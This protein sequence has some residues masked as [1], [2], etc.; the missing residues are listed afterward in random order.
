MSLYKRNNSPNWYYR[1]T[2]PGGG[3]VVQGSTGTSNKAHA[4]ELYDRL[5]V[6]LWNQAKLGHKPR[7]LW[8]D[9][10]VRYVGDRE[11]LSSLET[12]KTHLRWLDPH[13][14]GVALADIDRDRVDAI[15][16]AKRCEPRVVRTRNGPKP[17][18]ETIGEGT[19]RR[20][21]GVLMAVLHA[22][23]EWEWLDRA[24]V[25]KR[26][27]TTPKRV[28]WITPAQAERL[29]AELPAHLSDMARFSL[30]TG[31]RRSNVTGL[32]WSQVDLARRVAWIHPDQAK[33]RKAITVPLSDTAV[34][35]LRRQLSK[36]RAAEHIER[37]FVYRGSAI[38][39]P[40]TAAW[41][42]ALKRAGIRDFRWHDLRHTWASWHVQ[43]GT[44]LQ[45]L[46]ELGGWETLEMVQRYAHLSADHLARWVQP[47]L[48]T[49]EVIELASA[50]AETP[51]VAAG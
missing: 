24:P 22:A 15:A 42:K 31:L 50:S 40:N 30:E 2:P 1:L 47:H 13:L 51:K 39:Q 21:I 38:G 20:V 3:P 37:V 4:Q 33:A 45:V 32:E 28:R 44:P 16:H 49:A 41:R 19:V 25:L 18:G 7:Y 26:R 14:S 8:N 9:A 10:V 5:K 34:D 11:G 6:E 35:V 43:R 27:K 48:R 46:K 12:S 17:I 29:L 23:V 36:R